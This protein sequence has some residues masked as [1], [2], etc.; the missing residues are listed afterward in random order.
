M[1]GLTFVVSAAAVLCVGA[2]GGRLSGASVQDGKKLFEEETFGGN[3]RTCRTCHS[4]ETGTVSPED[5]QKRF[6]KNPGDPLFLHDGSDN[7]NGIGASRMQSDATVLIT[8]PLPPGVIM[9]GDPNIHSATFKR[10]I[11]TTINTPALE[12]VFM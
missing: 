1:K 11:P 2:L 10:G 5:A 4:R 6:R 9:D 8:I 12:H 7:G 3:G